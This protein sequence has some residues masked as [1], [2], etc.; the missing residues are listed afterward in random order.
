MKDQIHKDL[1]K[2]LRQKFKRAI[3]DHIERC[4]EV[5]I[6]GTDIAS[7]LADTLLHLVCGYF[8]MLDLKPQQFG[9]LCHDAYK[10]LQEDKKEQEA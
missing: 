10:E 7:G 9:Q 2:F 6:E 4:E 8:M 3:Q 5:E 1:R